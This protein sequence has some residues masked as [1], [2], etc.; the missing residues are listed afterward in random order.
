MEFL[1][2]CNFSSKKSSFSSNEV[3]LSGSWIG[4]SDRP[5]YNKYLAPHPSCP[6]SRRRGGLEMRLI[7]DGG[8]VMRPPQTPGSH[9]AKESLCWGHME[10]S[11]WGE[12]VEAPLP[13]LQSLVYAALHMDPLHEHEFISGPCLVLSLQVFLHVILV[14]LI[15]LHLG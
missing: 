12:E 11:V 14:P 7:T 1:I 2:L 8:S 6:P 5:S 9:R 10:D 4:S 15:W 13:V 3:N